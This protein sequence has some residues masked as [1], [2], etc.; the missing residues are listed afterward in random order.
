MLNRVAVGLLAGTLMSA[1]V[2][3]QTTAP[4]TTT[5]PPA[6]TPMAPATPNAGAAMNQGGTIQYVTQ[7]RPDL[8][9]ASRL[10][11]LS[12]YN[13]NN[14][15]VGDISEVLVNRQGQVEAVV[16]GVGGFLGICERNVAVPFNALQWQQEPART[17]QTT[18]APVTTGGTAGTAAPGTPATTGTTATTTTGAT[19]T[20]TGT[21]TTSTRGGTA[22]DP[23]RDYPE[24]AI[25]ANATKDQLEKAPEFRFAR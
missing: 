9:R 24:R 11:G 18:T 17:A 14:E 16:I 20:T 25:L 5:Q 7:N 15:K 19:G 13:N 8:W 23:A 22:G 1:S 3:A 2:G 21:M 10:E 4:A 12:V 6:T